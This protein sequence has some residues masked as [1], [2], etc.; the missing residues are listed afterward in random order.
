MFV[1][2]NQQQF[3]NSNADVQIFYGAH[4][5]AVSTYSWVKPKGVGS[6]YLMLIGA[7]GATADG[8]TGGGSGAVTVWY[9]SAQNVPDNLICNVAGGGRGGPSNTTVSYYG[10]SGSVTLLTANGANTSSGGGASS[11]NTFSASGFFNSVAGQNGTTSTTLGPSP[12]TFLSGAPLGVGNS[13][14]TAN[15]G[16]SNKNQKGYFQFQPIIVGIG[17][18]IGSDYGGPYYGCGGAAST[19]NGL[20]GPGLVLIASW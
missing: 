9:G 11:Q 4:K 7:G 20:G 17:S 15:Y 19:I 6:V 14:C 3:R 13:T 1:R 2:Q 5:G 12:T 10:S 16:Y 8:A 18:S